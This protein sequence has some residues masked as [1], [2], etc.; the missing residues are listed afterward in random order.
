MRKIGGILLG[1]GLTIIIIWVIYK[2]LQEAFSEL[3][4]YITIA[5]IAVLIGVCI[6]LISLIRERIRSKRKEASY[7]KEVD[8]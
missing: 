7:L 3:P 1:A 4:L 2:W 8:R 6:I 5:L